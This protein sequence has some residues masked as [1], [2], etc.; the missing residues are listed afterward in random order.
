MEQ[1]HLKIFRL[2]D[3]SSGLDTV[4]LIQHGRFCA[5]LEAMANHVGSALEFMPPT[6][7]SGGNIGLTINEGAIVSHGMNLSLMGWGE[8]PDL[9]ARENLETV[10][11]GFSRAIRLGDGNMGIKANDDSGQ[12][13]TT[14]F[15]VVK[16][17][18]AAPYH[19]QTVSVE[20]KLSEGAPERGERKHAGLTATNATPRP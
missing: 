12:A 5:A 16:D 4:G 9:A 11:A 17:G 1:E 14:F 20:K 8:T 3:Q 10:A 18:V 13:R 6:R 2:I 15:V 19:A 7:R